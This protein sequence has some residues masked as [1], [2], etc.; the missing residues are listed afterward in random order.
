[1]SGECARTSH[2]RQGAP[3][4]LLVPLL[5][6]RSWAPPPVAGS[7]ST[8]SRAAASA[9]TATRATASA[10]LRHER[11]GVGVTATELHARDHHLR[12]V[13]RRA[14]LQADAHALVTVLGH[15]PVVG[16][17]Q[18]TDR[19]A[20]ARE[21]AFRVARAAI[22]DAARTP[23]SPRGEMALAALGARD[24]ERQRLG[25]RRPALAAV[26]AIGVTRA[27]AERP[28][29]AALRYELALATLRALLAD[30]LN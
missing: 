12:Q 17:V 22:E 2:G 5:R 20:R 7:R 3:E 15:G 27:T 25:R 19:L 8:P 10:P 13:N 23:G 21:V 1:M 11:L 6:S 24:L 9:A 18:R 26:V 16:I 29:T 4:K 30:T 28:E 14:A